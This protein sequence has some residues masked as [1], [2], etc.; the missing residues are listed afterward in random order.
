MIRCPLVLS[1]I[2]FYAPRRSLRKS[3]FYV[4]FSNSDYCGNSVIRRLSREANNI[5]FDIDFF[6]RSS[7][8]FTN[9]LRS[10]L[11]E[12]NNNVYQ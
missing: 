6:G 3:L 7:L 4:Q 12:N 8:R 1:N 5:C 2:K 11:F 10:L 9:C